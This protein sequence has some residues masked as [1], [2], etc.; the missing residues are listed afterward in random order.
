[1][2][3]Y[4]E[5]TAEDTLRR[6]I[7]QYEGLKEA[8]DLFAQAGGLRATIDALV[9]RRDQVGEQISAGQARLDD[10]AREAEINLKKAQDEATRI[11]SEA[12]ASAKVLVEDAEQKVQ[13]ELD[14][15]TKAYE[16]KFAKLRSAIE[17]AQRELDTV[18]N[19]VTHVTQLKDVLVGQHKE[20]S[21]ALASVNAA[22]EKLTKR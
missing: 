13:A 12:E 17:S 21:E 22:I 16:E 14:E 20:A 18:R 1:M 10:I 2:A 15:R 19:E 11:V 7:V 6:L 8:A 9:K 5:R 4:P 3:E